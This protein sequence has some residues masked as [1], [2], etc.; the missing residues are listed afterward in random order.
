M[1]RNKKIPEKNPKKWRARKPTMAKPR[2]PFSS[3]LSTV[4][5]KPGDK[6][7][8]DP[9]RY[10]RTDETVIP[11]KNFVHLCRQILNEKCPA[12]YAIQPG[13]LLAFQ[14]A[15]EKHLEA[16]FKDAALCA[17]HA[18]RVTVTTK[19]FKLAIRLRGI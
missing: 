18:K 7:V 15:S 14:V 10:L 12:G 19:D 3:P 6:S 1:V 16:V 17:N 13:A 2:E 4:V 8:R 9:Y 11:K 5:P